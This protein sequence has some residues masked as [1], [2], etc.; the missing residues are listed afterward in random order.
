MEICRF[1]CPICQK[2]VI[3]DVPD[4][5]LEGLMALTDDFMYFRCSECHGVFHD[6][7]IDGAF[8]FEYVH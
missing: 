8:E 5:L 2:R 7:D 3:D 1:F 6:D 4:T